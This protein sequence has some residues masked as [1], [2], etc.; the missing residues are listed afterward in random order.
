MSNLTN[1]TTGHQLRYVRFMSW[2][3]LHNDCHVANN[4]KSNITTRGGD[5]WFSRLWCTCNNIG[6]VVSNASVSSTE[7]MVPISRPIGRLL[8]PL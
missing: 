5:G 6:N 7:L 2:N 4:A 3:S 8:Q 1:S